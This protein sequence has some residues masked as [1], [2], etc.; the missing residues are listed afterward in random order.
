MQLSEADIQKIKDYFAS[1]K[2][3]AAVYLHGSYAYGNPHKRSDLD[4]AVLF[5]GNVNLY[6]RL[7]RLYANFPKLSIKAE[8]EV[9]DINL[10]Q[11]PVFLRNVL[12]GKCI[13]SRDE[14]E[15][16]N[17]AVAAMNIYRDSEHLRNLKY[18]YMR[19]SFKEGTYGYRLLNS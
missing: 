4:I 3:V 1:Q 5:D 7:G 16:I 9:R 17:F 12:R 15:R 18:D 2:D 10:N 6:E 13:F 14:S 19:K 8:P 11:S